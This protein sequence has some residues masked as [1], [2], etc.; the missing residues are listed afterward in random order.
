MK[1]GKMKEKG[2][3]NRDR[4][5]DRGQEGILGKEMQSG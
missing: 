3:R 5:R 2:V 1:V 4:D